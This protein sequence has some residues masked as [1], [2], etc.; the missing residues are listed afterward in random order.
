[1]KVHIP[2]ESIQFQKEV[3][4]D[5]VTSMLE[6]YGRSQDIYGLSYQQMCNNALNFVELYIRS[7]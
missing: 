2:H 6:K 7:Q 3:A 1:M 5:N 4:N